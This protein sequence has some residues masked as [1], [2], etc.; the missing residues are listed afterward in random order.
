MAMASITLLAQRRSGGAL[1]RIQ[2]RGCGHTLM[3]L[4]EQQGLSHP[5]LCRAGTCGRCAVKVAVLHSE[6]QRPALRLGQTERETLYAGG[7][8]TRHQYDSPLLAASAPLWRL[9][10][11][12][13]PGEEDIVVAF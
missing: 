7:K 11:Q 4:I 12:Y 9:A 2:V 8:L 5:C 13:Q 10:C 1:E 3:E 6:G